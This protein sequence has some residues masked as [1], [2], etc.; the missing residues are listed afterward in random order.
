[1]RRFAFAVGCL[2]VLISGIGAG[3]YLSGWIDWPTSR[4]FSAFGGSGLAAALAFLCL[5][6]D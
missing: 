2:G 3:L 4:T 1:M 5:E 6:R